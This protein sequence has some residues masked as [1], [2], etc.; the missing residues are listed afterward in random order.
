MFDQDLSDKRSQ[1][2]KF[3]TDHG[4][5]EKFAKLLATEN[6]TVVVTNVETASFDTVKRV[7]FIPN[8]E[9]M[10]YHLRVALTAHE[11][12]HALRTPSD[13]WIK[14]I[15]SDPRIKPILNV[16]E[17]IRIDRI[18]K[19]LFPGLKR[20]YMKSYREL[21][22]RDFYGMRD[23]DPK[24][25]NL[26]DRINLEFNT[27]PR[28]LVIPFAD[29]EKMWVERC[30]NTRSFEDVINLSFELF[31]HMME[32]QKNPD[33]DPPPEPPQDQPQE[34][35]DGQDDP[36]DGGKGDKPED[37]ENDENDESEGS[38]AD[39]DSDEENEETDESDDG[40]GSG[41]SDDDS[42][43]SDDSDGSDSDDSD[44]DSD[45]NDSD[46]AGSGDSDGSDD[47]G[48]DD[49]SDSVSDGS[50][51]D[52]DG[53]N[54]SDES[55][56]NPDSDSDPDDQ[57]SNGDD[58][59]D[60]STDSD[61]DGNPKEVDCNI[62]DGEDNDGHGDSDVEPPQEM[63]HEYDPDYVPTSETDK[64]YQR[65]LN[66]S[67]NVDIGFYSG[68]LPRA[69]C[70]KI[71]DYK[72]FVSSMKTYMQRGINKA[73]V[74]YLFVEQEKT[75]KQIYNY[76][77]KQFEM[78]RQVTDYQEETHFETGELDVARLSEYLV[79]DDIFRTDS[80]E[81]TDNTKHRIIMLTD[82]SA[83][84]RGSKMKN[85]ILQSMIVAKF[86]DAVGIPYDMYGFFS[87]GSVKLN[88]PVNSPLHY[89]YRPG[90]I[91]T[92]GFSMVQLLSSDMKPSEK[93]T[94]HKAML[95]MSLQSWG[96]RSPFTMNS[97]PLNEALIVISGMLSELYTDEKVSFFL[98]TD[99]DGD[100]RISMIDTMSGREVGICENESVYTFVDPYTK[101][102]YQIDTE[103]HD[104]YGQAVPKTL[105]DII[106]TKC[107]SVNWYLITSGIMPPTDIVCMDY[108]YFT[109]NHFVEWAENS[110]VTVPFSKT[111]DCHLMRLTDPKIE[112]DDDT[113]KGLD[114][115]DAIEKQFTS[116]ARNRKVFKL[117][118]DVLTDKIA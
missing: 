32:N 47:K 4:V 94:A 48:D 46:G 10:G 28:D 45:S 67:A 55:D 30:K 14:I 22:E 112:L 117:M 108:E 87:Q 37:S 100:D 61:S 16:V 19:L 104:Q 116:S 115:I 81:N 9:D 75:I 34:P 65:N 95:D 96:S 50:D 85:S 52:S 8:W 56:N 114:N 25:L 60:G 11:V 82:C 71:V 53:D 89:A 40:G 26:I 73:D 21:H 6:I 36:Q 54:D 86:C 91:R 33:L 1:D 106:N 58:T 42:D 93:V 23:R 92:G 63:P 66:Q 102:T 3:S 103:K 98:T 69:D 62:N 84:M 38:G 109:E 17:D 13:M 2:K 7:L 27:D 43:D 118:C 35:Q 20:D 49:D 74:E 107:H 41:D 24:T 97:T 111:V 90:Q 57:T 99:G 88:V 110:M 77:R 105:L 12:G 5:N 113:T 76:L 15:K 68:A 80:M 18:M 51:D 31:N 70:K 59:G 39:S 64:E 29:S 79:S 101:I 83:S 78:K 44:S 72:T